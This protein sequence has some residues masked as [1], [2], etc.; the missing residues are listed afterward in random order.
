MLRWFHK[1][2]VAI[3]SHKG[4]N[5]VSSQIASSGLEIWTRHNFGSILSH[6][7]VPIPLFTPSMSPESMRQWNTC[8][9]R[10]GCYVYSGMYQII[11]SQIAKGKSEEVLEFIRQREESKRER[12]ADLW[13]S[14]LNSDWMI[15]RIEKCAKE[16]QKPFVI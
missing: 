9:S 4:A 5:P 16:L 7:G 8:G 13:N 1:V 11:A 10:A 3:M 2:S 12:S 15:V 6:I 14:K